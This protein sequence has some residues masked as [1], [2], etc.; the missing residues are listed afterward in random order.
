MSDFSGPKSFEEW[1]EVYERRAG[2]DVHFLLTPGE[3]IFYNPDYGFFTWWIDHENKQNLETQAE[4]LISYAKELFFKMFH[5]AFKI[6][7]Y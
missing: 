6:A 1:V 7:V 2:D 3:Q 5:T 4:R